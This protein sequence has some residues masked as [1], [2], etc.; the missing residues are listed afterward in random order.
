MTDRPAGVPRP[1][2]Q[3]RG[4]YPADYSNRLVSLQ[5]SLEAKARAT[6]LA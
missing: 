6:A 5:R 2:P 1:F 4:G 3:T